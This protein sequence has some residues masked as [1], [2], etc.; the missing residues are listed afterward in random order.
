MLSPL[1]KEK[2]KTEF[3]IVSPI[4]VN[5]ENTLEVNNKEVFDLFA[6][7]IHRIDKDVLRCDRNYWY[8]S[9]GEN[10]NK[11]RNVIYT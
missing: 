11:L 3:N 4:S 6:L 9:S 5:E 10:L 1:I 2:S 8:F 7:N